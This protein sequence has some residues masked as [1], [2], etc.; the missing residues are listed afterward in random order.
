MSIYTLIWHSISIGNWT[1]MSI[2][3][4]IRHFNSSGN[5]TKYFQKGQ[6]YHFLFNSLGNWTK[7][8]H[9]YPYLTFKF[10]SNCRKMSI[11]TLL[12]HFNS[13]G[14]WTKNFQNGNF[15]HLLLNSLGNWTKMV[16]LYPTL[17]YTFHWELSKK[18]HILT[19]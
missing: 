1:K 18:F 14:N 11:D 8:V 16:Y 6:F 10:P 12:W 9:L 3:T 19:S 13:L 15:Y 17:T 7:M 5:R 2:Y 4:L